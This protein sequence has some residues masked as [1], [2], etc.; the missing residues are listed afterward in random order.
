MLADEFP[1]FN[2]VPNITYRVVTKDSSTGDCYTKEV[3]MQCH[4]EEEDPTLVVDV[5]WY[6]GGDIVKQYAGQNGIAI[7]NFPVELYENDTSSQQSSASF[8]SSNVSFLTHSR[9]KAL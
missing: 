1:T 3:V 2:A 4:I 7:A 9:K 8:L 5:Y 6:I